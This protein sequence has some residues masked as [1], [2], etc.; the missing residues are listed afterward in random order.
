[1]PREN[2]KTSLGIAVRLQGIPRNDD[3]SIR[4]KEEQDVRRKLLS[5]IESTLRKFSD[6]DA[7]L[8]AEWNGRIRTDP[9]RLMVDI[10]VTMRPAVP[11]ME[12]HNNA[13]QA[14]QWQ[15]NTEEAIDKAIRNWL[16]N[17]FD[18]AVRWDDRRVWLEADR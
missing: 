14:G 2:Y 8:P 13:F 9:R 11:A 3:G 1:M 7:N 10:R 12:W 17:A 5:S 16:R 18:Q 6:A 4:A 15:R